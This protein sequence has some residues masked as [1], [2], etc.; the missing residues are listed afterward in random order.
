MIESTPTPK[1]KVT[2]GSLGAKFI[3]SKVAK[4]ARSI[5]ELR[6]LA[7][8]SNPEKLSAKELI[9]SGSKAIRMPA[10]P[11]GF[12]FSEALNPAR[13]GGIEFTRTDDGLISL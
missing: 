2:N 11:A 3:Q 13:N 6:E 1:T 4:Q 5:K 12:Y 7:E 10:N 8:K 9:A